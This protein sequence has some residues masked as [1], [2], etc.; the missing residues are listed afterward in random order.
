MRTPLALT[1]VTLVFLSACG[2]Y[3]RPLWHDQQLPSGKVVKVT[4][5]H[6]VWGVEH[7]ERD[8]TKDSFALEYVSVNAQA[9]PAQREAEAR[10]VFELIRP[11]SE[12][13]GFRMA[14]MAAFPSLERQGRYDLY[15]FDRQPDGRWSATRSEAKVFAND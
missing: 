11:I 8:A 1:A 6:L 7:D 5:F 3:S 4:S 9:E 13:W 10:E 12:Q 15:R 14:T 2:G